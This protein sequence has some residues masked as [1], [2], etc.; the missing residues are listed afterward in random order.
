MDFRDH[1]VSS[2]TVG[3]YEAHDRNGFEIYGFSYGEDT[4][5]PMRKRLERAFDRFMDVRAK[6]DLETAALARELEIDIAI[7]LAGYT[8]NG[9]SGIFAARA[10]PV[11]VSYLGYLGTMGA[12]YIDY[13]VADATVIPEASRAAFSE[14]VAVL[15]SYQVNDAGRPMPDKV[16]TRA[17][18][19]LPPEGFVYCCF[20]NTY[21]ITPATFDSW[22]RI[23]GAVEGSVLFLY[24]DVESAAANLRKEAA[25]R[26][27][28]AERL[29]FGKRLP[30]PEYL[31]RFRAADLFLDTLPYNAGATASDALWMGLPVLT[32]QGEAL[33]AR[34]AASLLRAAGLAELITTTRAAYEA[35]AIGLARDP[36]RHAELKAKLARNR[37]TA[38]LFDTGAF[39]RNIEEAFRQMHGRHQAGLAPDHIVVE[40]SAGEKRA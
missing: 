14:K 40:Q 26:G 18:L 2:L 36:V 11:Q 35:L 34:Q 13:V 27:I 31:A 32:L 9:R 39:T 19:G 23:L 6:S 16:F 21:K 33:A 20:N 8:D 24:A 28:A 3:M 30:M 4:G 17:E 37:P 1:P 5:D 12:D 7:D 25:A 15:P 22:M 38:A 29:V 10:A